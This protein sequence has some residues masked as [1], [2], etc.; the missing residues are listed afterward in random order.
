MF[1]SHAG[2]SHLIYN[3]AVFVACDKQAPRERDGIIR[4]KGANR[5]NSPNQT[6]PRYLMGTACAGLF[7]FGIMTTFLGATLPELSTRLAFDLERSGASLVSRSK[8][9]RS[10]IGHGTWWMKRA[11]SN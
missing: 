5:M 1:L 8:E 6:A 2:L 3:P 9:I 4:G 10:I 7:T 11:S